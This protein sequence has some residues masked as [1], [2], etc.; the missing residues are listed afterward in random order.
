MN[1]K[2]QIKVKHP[3]IRP[4]LEIKTEASGKYLVRVVNQT[5]AL[6]REINE[7]AGSKDVNPK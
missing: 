4:G 6:V 3:L 2:Y 1:N 7:S 5:M